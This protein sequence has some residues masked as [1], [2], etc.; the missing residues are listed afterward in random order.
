MLDVIS[1]EFGSVDGKDAESFG[2][3]ICFI[4]FKIPINYSRYF[5]ALSILPA[6]ADVHTN[7]THRG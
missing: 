2:I 6:T 3:P 4:L 1:L 5:T 7:V